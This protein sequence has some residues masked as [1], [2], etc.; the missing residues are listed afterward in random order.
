MEFWDHKAPG[1]FTTWEPHRSYMIYIYNILECNLV[2]NNIILYIMVVYNGIYIGRF[3]KSWGYPLHHAVIMD[4]HINDHM[5]SIV[6][7]PW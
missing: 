5:I 3:P 1:G 6:Q 2:C 7:Q 4:D